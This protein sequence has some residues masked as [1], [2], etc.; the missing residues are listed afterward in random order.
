[1]KTSIKEVFESGSWMI[2]RIHQG[3][4][5]KTRRIDAKRRFPEAD[6]KNSFSEWCSTAY[7]DRLAREHYGKNTNDFMCFCY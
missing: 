6:G 4:S 5:N 1:M 3:T 2:Q 7:A